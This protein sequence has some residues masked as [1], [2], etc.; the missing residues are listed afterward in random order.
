MLTATMG[1][2]T[3]RTQR[4][5]G[6]MS[7]GPV[8]FL[9]YFFVSGYSRLTVLWWFQV[10]SERAEPYIAMYPFSPKRPSRLPHNIEQSCLCYRVGPCWLSMLNIAVCTRPPVMGRFR[11]FR[12]QRAQP[13][14]G[15]GT[16]L[17]PWLG[18]SYRPP[19]APEASPPSICDS[20]ASF[21]A[22]TNPR[23]ACWVPTACRGL[24]RRSC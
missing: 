17:L 4:K 14:T 18:L 11:R 9:T 5:T 12:S 1:S 24:L 23:S 2:P 22:F 3:V 16:L 8:L 6:W 21:S 10:N 7:C 20:I 13:C 15:S 19:E